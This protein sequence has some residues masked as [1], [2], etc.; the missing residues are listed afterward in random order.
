MI[1]SG[2]EFVVF[3]LE[4]NTDRSDPPE[5]EIIEIG[6]VLVSDGAEVGAF[7]TLVRPTRRLRDFT[8]QLTGLTDGELAS[9]P[10]PADALRSLYDFVDGRPMIAHNGLRYDFPLLESAGAKVGVPVPAVS[11][12]DSLELAHLAFPRV[13]KGIVAN[14]DGSRPPTGRS[15]DEL[16]RYL[17]SHDPRQQHRA[18]DDSPAA[19]RTGRC[20]PAAPCTAGVAASARRQSAISSSAALGAGRRTPPVVGLPGIAV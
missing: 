8:C 5:H 7:Q 10:L 6:G 13:G 16:A 17:L 2:I 20:S 11:R 1:L 9:A 18:L 4:A 19:P 3:D 15:L 12:L 14:I